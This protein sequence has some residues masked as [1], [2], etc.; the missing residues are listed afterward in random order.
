MAPLTGSSGTAGGDGDDARP[1]GSHVVD[2]NSLCQPCVTAI[3]TLPVTTSHPQDS[4]SDGVSGLKPRPFDYSYDSNM[5]LTPARNHTSMWVTQNNTSATVMQRRTVTREWANEW[6]LKLTAF[7]A[8]CE[9]VDEIAL[10]DCV[11]VSVPRYAV[12]PPED[13]DSAAFAFRII[14]I[15]ND[16][17]DWYLAGTKTDVEQWLLWIKAIHDRPSHN[18]P[19]DSAAM[20]T[21][22]GGPGQK[23]A[24]TMGA[25]LNRAMDTSTP[26]PGNKTMPAPLH[27]RP[28]PALSFAT[29]SVEPEGQP[30]ASR[31]TRSPSPA[32][33]RPPRPDQ[34]NNDSPSPSKRASRRQ[35]QSADVASNIQADYGD[36]AHLILGPLKQ[37]RA[38]DNAVH[39][40]NLTRLAD[41]IDTSHEAILA[42]TKVGLAHFR[43]TTRHN[44]EHMGEVL[45]ANSQ[46]L[47]QSMDANA[48][49]RHAATT[50]S[51]D[52]VSC[53]VK[54][55]HEALDVKVNTITDT[56]DAMARA[57]T[58]RDTLR[59]RL[60]EVQDQAT[61]AT[62]RKQDEIIQN[63]TQLNGDLDRGLQQVRDKVD[64]A[65]K[66]T[67]KD[68]ID[69]AAER[70]SDLDKRL[71]QV[72]DEVGEA[73]T[74]TRN[75]VSNDL[76]RRLQLVQDAVI[77][78]AAKLNGDLDGRLQRVGDAAKTNRDDIME[79][80]A[81]RNRDLDRRLQQVQDEVDKTATKTQKDILDDA[82]K[83]NDDLDR[84]LQQVRDAAKTNR[85]DIMEDAAKRNDD[86]DRRLQQV[87]DEVAGAATS[88]Q[89]AVSAGIN[90]LSQRV[91]SLTESFQGVQSLAI[92]AA[93]SQQQVTTA[94]HTQN[95]IRD[96]IQDLTAGSQRDRAPKEGRADQG[97]YEIHQFLEERMTTMSQ[98]LELMKGQLMGLVEHNSAVSKTQDPRSRATDDAPTFS[99]QQFGDMLARL[100]TLR[101]HF[102][103]KIPQTIT[104][105]P[106]FND[107]MLEVRE[108]FQRRQQPQSSTSVDDIQA[109]TRTHDNQTIELRQELANERKRRMEAEQ[110]HATANLRLDM[111][112]TSHS[113]LSERNHTLSSNFEDAQSHAHLFRGE[114]AKFVRA[115]ATALSLD[116]QLAISKSLLTMSNREDNIRTLKSQLHDERTRNIAMG[117]ELIIRRHKS[118]H[119]RVEFP[120]S[121]A[122]A[123]GEGEA[124]GAIVMRS[125]EPI[126]EPDD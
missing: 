25:R 94:I 81:K 64:D 61:A 90:T 91:Q 117:R 38:E 12:V 31:Q 89:A 82:A 79:D 123:E 73:A 36:F 75:A 92:S 56:L 53:S 80:A 86:L 70:S 105:P 125:S 5:G 34:A 8:G 37:H 26:C 95:N 50:A 122:G 62:T 112:K 14:R 98:S 67:Q 42:T 78:N 29:P 6:V 108:F 16:E 32:K 101:G 35:H 113:A 77:S 87:R 4:G 106:D 43:A 44:F 114:F 39:E 52:A 13:S 97:T 11:T 84:R 58:A 33:S 99:Q 15:G 45:S 85:D 19:S 30:S 109:I 65:S 59:T 93:A 55:Q 124:S 46:D 54:T 68:I 60:I 103:T 119:Y 51:L 126:L 76:Q 115:F 1:T 120:S 63:I 71:L 7:D 18:R 83:R 40:R 48:L 111:V 22:S 66:K 121:T 3:S 100:E 41:R 116:H 74:R 104:F 24:A 10:R 72:R 118:N 88:T 47:F 28:I 96:M 23:S 107:T 110:A 27:G 21:P 102:D 2:V 17:E 9:I 49:R 20:A 69:D 57:N